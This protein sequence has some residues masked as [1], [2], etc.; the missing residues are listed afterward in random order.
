MGK[1]A[2]GIGISFAVIIII[3][4]ASLFV[5]SYTQLNVTLNDVQFHS[6]DWESL[7]WSVL[8]KTGLHMLSEDWFGAAFNLVQGINLNLV[9]GITNNGLLPVYIPDLSYDIMVN[10]ISAGKGTSNE[11][12]TI[13]PGQTIEIISLQNLQKKMLSPAINSIVQ[14]EGIIDLNVK[15]IADFKLLG[16]SIPIPFESSRQ[17]S[18]YDEVRDKIETEIQKNQNQQQDMV[19]SVKKS[20][21]NT[22]DSLIDTFIGS[23]SLHVKSQDQMVVDSIYKVKPGSY[24][25]SVFTLECTSNIQAGFVASATLGDNII[26]FILDEDNFKKYEKGQTVSTYYDSGKTES[27][28]FKISLN[29]G[30]YYIV[31]SN[32]YSNFSTKTVQLQAVSSCM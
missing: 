15:G 7:S 24:R 6:I 8:L 10:G 1:A 13:N 28:M 11:Q 21:E 22:L 3:V 4:V 2:V 12:V 16:L 14:S 30:T 18:I 5:Y 31:M 27:D 19:S 32:T 25:Y 20:L 9:F 26:V 29:P 23:D 17:I